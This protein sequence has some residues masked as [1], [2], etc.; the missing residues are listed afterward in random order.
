VTK[1]ALFVCALLAFSALCFA[2]KSYDIVL[3]APTKAGAVDLKPGQYKLKVDG[4]NAVFTSSQNSKTFSAPVKVQT[5]EK[6]FETT[7]VDTTTEN[8]TRVMK[9]IQL[10]GTSTTLEFGI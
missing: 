5:G 1:K 8:G 3:T 10:G 9:E 7:R 2:A 6:K 4:P